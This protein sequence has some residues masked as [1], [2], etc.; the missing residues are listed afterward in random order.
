MDHA[1]IPFPNC[2]L[3]GRALQQR[4]A[5]IANLNRRALVR[6]SRSGR[7]L[8]LNYRADA[9]PDIQGMV[10]DEKKC[11]SFL[12][13]DVTTTPAGIELTITVP[14]DQADNADVLL[15][16][17]STANSEATEGTSCCGACS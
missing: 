12:N 7:S 9:L 3:D 10:A 15:S 17:F 2:S 14:E 6:L 8:V 16:P 13:F 11:C 5:A 4:I 1:D